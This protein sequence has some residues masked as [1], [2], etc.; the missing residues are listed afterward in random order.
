MAKIE[1]AVNK[2][3]PFLLVTEA[4]LTGC[5]PKIKTENPTILPTRPS[6]TL[7]I[8]PPTPTLTLTATETATATTEPTPGWQ[9]PSTE[10]W[11]SWLADQNF[12][13]QFLVNQFDP[14]QYI[15]LNPQYKQ[16][17]IDA[18]YYGNSCGEAVIAAL[19][20]M[21]TFRK[22]GNNPSIVISDVIN[23]LIKETTLIK[24]NGTN[25]NERNFKLAIDYFGQKQDL[26]STIPLVTYPFYVFRSEWPELFKDAKR[27]VLDKDGVLVVLLEKYGT[28]HV[29]IIS[30]FDDQWWAVMIDSF[31]GA[32]GVEDLE[33][34][35]EG[36]P[37]LYQDA[38]QQ[39]ILS[40]T[41]VIPTH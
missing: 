10:T 38:G 36:I 11:I 2:L 6:I 18:N 15:S 27:R 30:G 35:V 17:S 13:E 34:Y 37:H 22:T 9:I 26:F 40:M 1:L 28:G 19:I 7:T 24:S 16:E 39:V 41:G 8:E 3:L 31:G 33:S 4:I 14:N 29:V 25:M 20:N 5:G 21:Y 12:L 23:E 32:V